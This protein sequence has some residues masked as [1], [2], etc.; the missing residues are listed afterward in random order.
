MLNK[1]Q[2]RAIADVQA[3]Y[4]HGNIG[5]VARVLSFL[6]RAALKKTQQKEILEYA[7]QLGVTNHSDFIICN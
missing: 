6:H 3:H 7:Q 5:A 2:I 1:S 4:N